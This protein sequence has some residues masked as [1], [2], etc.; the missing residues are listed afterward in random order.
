M[1]NH[2]VNIWYVTGKG[3]LSHN[4]GSIEF[5]VFARESVDWLRNK[6]TEL[7]D[8]TLCSKSMVAVK[9]YLKRSCVSAHLTY[10][11]NKPIVLQS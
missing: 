11:T 7:C 1:L 5:V 3:E 4:G 2:T 9:Q 10:E 8:L 6:E